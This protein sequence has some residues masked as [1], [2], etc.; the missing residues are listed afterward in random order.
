MATILA[1]TPAAA[2]AA[3]R[4]KAATEDRYVSL[5]AYRGL[6]MILLI[7]VGFGFGALKGHPVYGLMAAQFDHVPWEGMVF[8]DL[9]QPAFMFMVGAA[10]PFAIA[11]R[12]E[13]GATF[14][15]NLWHVG[16][17]SLK[18]LLLSQVLASVSAGEPR[19][20]L[21]NV[22]CQIAFTYFFC[23]LIMHMQFRW[24]AA[25]AG[26]ILAGHWALFALL[27]G[28]EGP[29]SRTGNIGQVVDLAVLGK[30]YSGYYITINFISSTVTTL[31][32]VWTAMLLR[33]ER[34][35]GQKLKIL[36]AFTLGCLALGLALTPFNPM[37]KRIWT[38]S[39]TLFSAGWVLL[40]ML[41]FVW[42]IEVKGYRK[43]AFPMVVVGMNCIFI[44]SFKF[45]LGGWVRRSLAVFT[46]N[47]EFIG[48][49]APVAQACAT[50]LVLW[51]LCYWLWR[52]KIFVKL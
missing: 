44:Y 48:T 35:Q 21:I 41:A 45:V 43:W 8:W 38:A 20:Q 39:F 33:S 18:L 17:R 51:Y 24:Q 19:F 25:T 28:P 49:L 5:D 2:P 37:V 52:R 27:P 47:F 50:L 26:L 22:L 30:T 46:R 31:F 1:E 12:I 29:F 32:G 6:I 40:G 11:R 4:P 13:R 9:V 14:R 16:G 3:G 34:K 42:L 23:F 10:M 7:S 36:A 15:Q